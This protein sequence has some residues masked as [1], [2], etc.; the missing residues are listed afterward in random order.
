MADSK[1]GKGRLKNKGTDPF[2]GTTQ[3]LPLKFSGPFFKKKKKQKLLWP[4]GCFVGEKKKREQSAV[5][6]VVSLNK[7]TFCEVEEKKKKY[8][9]SVMHFCGRC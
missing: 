8:R 2:R 7:S 5:N 3:G 9:R 6:S 1:T 4:P